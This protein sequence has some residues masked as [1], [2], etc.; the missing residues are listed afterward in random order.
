MHHSHTHVYA[1]QHGAPRCGVICYLLTSQLFFIDFCFPVLSI[2]RHY[3]ACLF[4]SVIDRVFVF[5]CVSECTSST[6]CLRLSFCFF[7]SSLILLTAP[8]WLYL[9]V[10]S[11]T[12]RTNN[13]Q[14]QKNT[15]TAAN[16]QQRH[17]TTLEA[18]LSYSDT[19]TDPHTHPHT[20]ILAHVQGHHRSTSPQ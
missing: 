20:R 19:H 5:V 3:T 10:P 11:A 13:K 4:R 12:R 16:I 15:S 17:T 6:F 7:S 14:K 9:Y 18:F 2:T 8:S 1:A